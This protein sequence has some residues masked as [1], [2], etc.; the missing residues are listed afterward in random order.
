MHNKIQQKRER[1][2]KINLLLYRGNVTTHVLYVTSRR[3]QGQNWRDVMGGSSF[4]RK[5]ILLMYDLWHTLISIFEKR[6]LKN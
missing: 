2:L 3:A 4:I 6:F 5:W 1:V